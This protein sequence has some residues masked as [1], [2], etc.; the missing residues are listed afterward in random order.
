MTCMQI[1]PAISPRLDGEDPELDVV[2]ASTGARREAPHLL[3]LVGL[4][5]VCRSSRPAPRRVQFA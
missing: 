4:A 1:H 5:V 2:C 3:D